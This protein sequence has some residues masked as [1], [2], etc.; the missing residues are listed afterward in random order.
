V[1]VAVTDKKITGW[2]SLSRWSDRCAYDSTAELSVYV[3]AEERGK[4]IGRLLMSS[5]V[6]EGRRA[7][8]HTLI[9]RISEGNEIS[10][11]MHEQMGFTHIGV[12][13]EV[14]KKF[15]K[16]LDVLMMQKIYGPRG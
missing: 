6:E 7:G 13:K 2:A 3:D 12:M 10:V 5:I 4:G 16:L 14:G 9:S 8:L 15:G 1:I 11:K